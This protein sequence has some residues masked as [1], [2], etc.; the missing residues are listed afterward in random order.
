MKFYTEK[1]KYKD[2]KAKLKVKRNEKEKEKEQSKNI[3][4]TKKKQCKPDLNYL[5]IKY[6]NTD[7]RIIC[8]SNNTPSST[9]GIC[10]LRVAYFV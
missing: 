8:S 5:D 7:T 4:K 9:F 2:E 10:L 3:N 6:F 1:I